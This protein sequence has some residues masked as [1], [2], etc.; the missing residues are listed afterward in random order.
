MQS[1]ERLDN[2]EWSQVDEA[3]RGGAWQALDPELRER[4]ERE[5]ATARIEMAIDLNNGKNER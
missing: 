5:I 3:N 4:A 1:H 2:D